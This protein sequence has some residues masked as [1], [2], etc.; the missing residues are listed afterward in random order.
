[1][2][3]YRG[4]K[5]DLELFRDLMNAVKFSTAYIWHKIWLIIWK[6]T[7]K[8]QTQAYNYFSLL[9]QNKTN[10]INDKLQQLNQIDEE[11]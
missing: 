10:S 6:A 11:L 3:L 8:Y 2:V 4:S 9:T 5:T 7:S 1:M